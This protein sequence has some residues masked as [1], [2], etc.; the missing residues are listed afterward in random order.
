MGK[1]VINLFSGMEVGR[2][3]AKELNWDIDKWYSSE[4]DKY[5]IQV[6]DNNHEDLIKLGSII[7]WENWNI[8]WS[9]VDVIL[10]GSPCQGFSR[11]GKGLNFEDDRSKLFFEFIDILN[12]T[13]KFNS[14]VK[15]MLENVKMKNEWKDVITEYVGIEPIEI[16]SKLNSAANRPRMY[17]SNIEGIEQPKDANIRLLD[18]LEENVA[19]EYI[20]Y[21]GLKIDKSISE[22]SIKLIDV[23]DGEVR[24]KQAVK[25][26][27]I[28]AN[29][30][31][32]LNL[33][34]PLSKTRRGRVVNQK[35]PTLDCACN[36]CVLVDGV[37]R[38]FTIKEM[39]RLQCL[40]DD[41][42]DANIPITARKKAIG[43]GWNLETIKH[44]LSYYK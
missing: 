29:N 26:G 7:D 20:D 12:H 24:I 6:A 36:I 27:Y 16:N 17:W 32:G 13:K 41:Y 9:K 43:N 2:Q 21:K 34:F 15:F 10:A 5:A 28:I 1:V 19:I 30:G 37:I 38:K 44:I 23:V 25:K 31:D 18:I 33:S 42:T 8:D 40:P 39:E 3:V 4:V 14:E 22:D 11:A 35:S